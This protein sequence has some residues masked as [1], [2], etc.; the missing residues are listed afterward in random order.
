MVHRTNTPGCPCC[1]TPY[2]DVC[3][4]CING[5]APEK[6]KVTISGMVTVEAG[7]DCE[8]E[9]DGTWLLP[10]ITHITGQCVWRYVF[11]G[12]EGPCEGW[13]SSLG[14]PLIELTISRPGTNV[15]RIQVQIWT[16][17]AGQFAS[18]LFFRKDASALVDC[19][20]LQDV[21]I[22]YLTRD[23]NNL[24]CD[25]EDAVVKVTAV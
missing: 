7:C 4:G 5:F 12:G 8:N 16:G 20:N 3:T 9:W 24:L 1:D 6:F 21:L 14:G 2:T 19:M 23:G 13:T 25:G 15:Y 10:F 18:K 17:A 11:S 22:P